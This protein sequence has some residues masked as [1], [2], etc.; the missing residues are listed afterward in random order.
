MPTVFISHGA[1]TIALE[2]QPSRRFLSALGGRLARPRAIVVV[3]AHW[4]TTD[5]CVLDGASLN[6]LHD[7]YGFDP[8]YYELRY[9]VRGASDV[10]AGIASRLGAAGI[11]VSCDSER[12]LDH[13]AWIPLSLMYPAADIPVTQI[14]VCPAQSALFHWRVGRALSALHHDGVLIL[15]SGAMTHNLEEF[16]RHRTTPDALPT[17]PW[18]HEFCAWAAERIE[19]GD[20]D[21]LIGWRDTA[22]AAALAH[23]SNEHFLPLHVAMGAAGVSWTGERIH[24]GFMYGAIGMDA[25]IFKPRSRHTH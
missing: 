2:D 14:S 19:S 4:E 3:S 17:P 10:A 15:G 22:P 16:R 6:T 1:P 18:A 5:V 25:Y 20:D 8:A 13:G 11:R 23:P 21:A 7:F 24:H 12:G 9:P